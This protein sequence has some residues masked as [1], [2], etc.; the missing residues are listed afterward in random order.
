MIKYA[1]SYISDLLDNLFEDAVIPNNVTVSRPFEYLI[2][3]R[4]FRWVDCLS[5]M[6]G[7]GLELR[8]R[9]G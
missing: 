2:C 1:I 9:A 3:C 4:M 6:A 5:D 8:V 7:L